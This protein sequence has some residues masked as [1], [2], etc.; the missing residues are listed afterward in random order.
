MSNTIRNENYRDELIAIIKDV[1]KELIERAEEMVAED[2]SY[3]T[4]FH[5]DVDIPQPC[6]G[7][8]LISWQ[9]ETFCTNYH[10]RVFGT[11]IELKKKDNPGTD[12]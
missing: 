4:D 10:N 6:E 2:A 8:P 11:G 3:I 9:M 1:G 5:I 7:Y 12:I